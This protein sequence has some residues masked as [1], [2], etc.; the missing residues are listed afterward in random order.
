MISVVIP[1]YNEEKLIEKTLDAL[2]AQQTK[3]EFEVI[4]VDNN[5]TDRT[6]DKVLSYK[7][8]LNIKLVKEKK[9]GRSPARRRGFEEAKGDIIFS[10]DADTIVPPNWIEG[11][12]PH[13][14]D[15]KVVA[16][17]GRSKLTDCG[18]F[19]NSNFNF[20]QPI[21]LKIYKLVMGYYW[22]GGFNFVIRK[23]AYEASGGFNP[24]LNSW[25]DTD[26]AS[27]VY[28]VGK[29]KYVS[30]PYVIFSGRRFK[31][32][33]IQGLI[34]YMKSWTTWYRQHDENTIHLSDIR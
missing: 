29:I 16:L 2:V 15:E 8:S 30:N 14:R 7:H 33:Y 32:G 19:V 23:S 9:K 1:A 18:W 20:Y 6:A 13:L 11:M 22:L 26:L 4:V 31:N 5:S 21:S 10:T 28:K 24:T 3:Q 17:T 27:R 34:Q 25:E 12:L